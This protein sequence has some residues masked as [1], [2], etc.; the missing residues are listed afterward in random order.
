[1]DRDRVDPD[2]P[3]SLAV[4]ACI[5]LL[6]VGSAL[7]AQRPNS[8]LEKAQAAL[9]EGNVDAAVAEALRTT[10]DSADDRFR[11]ALWLHQ[12]GVH[13]A[14]LELVLPLRKELPNRADV[15]FLEGSI[16][17]AMNRFNEAAQALQP[18]AAIPNAPARLLALL[19]MA[20]SAAGKHEQAVG[21]LESATRAQPENPEIA[22]QLASATLRAGRAPKAAAWLTQVRARLTAKPEGVEHL[23]RVELDWAA[24]ALARGDSEAARFALSDLQPFFEGREEYELLMANL[25][26]SEDRN[27]EALA[28]L[29]RFQRA[30]SARLG[31]AAGVCHFNLGRYRDAI[32]CFEEARKADP[33][34][35]EAIH[36]LGLSL[37]NLADYPAAAA[38]QAE[39]VA[40][41]PRSHRYRFHWGW[42]LL[43][44]GSAKEAEEQFRRA[45]GLAPDYAPAR[46]ALARMQLERGEVNEAI[47]ELKAAVASEP[48]FDEP[49]YLL[50][51]AFQ[52][53]G[54]VETA[55]AWLKRF[56][57]LKQEERDRKR[58]G[59]TAQVK[60]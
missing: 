39:A 38:R 12:R 1:V 3:P 41:S 7:P 15:V 57:A 8:S 10:S 33:G 11:V 25:L 19:G 60:P 52:R 27:E 49:Y 55:A 32:A 28:R 31:F 2:R 26:Q 14:A 44:M 29:Q 18:L 4:L 54:E 50:S 48:R 22:V 45:I 13:R 35:S 36:Y 56:R 51:Q 37:A 34:L 47:N 53:R 6:M 20:L 42:V 40:A 24:S 58:M 21:Y 46:A 43:R 17:F 30:P 9:N 23:H 5:A 59:M 16:L